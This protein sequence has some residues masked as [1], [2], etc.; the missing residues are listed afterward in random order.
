LSEG[1]PRAR[2][3]LA[4]YADPVG[5]WCTSL[6][7][8]AEVMVPCLE[9]ADA[10]SVIE[11]GAYSGD[12][13]RL[14]A[15]WA[16]KGG[17]KV[18]AV[19]PAPKAGLV[20][21]AEERE[22][23]ELVRETSLEGLRRVELADVVIIDGDHNYWTVSEEL[24]LMSERAAGGDLPLLMFHDVGWPHAF[25]DDYFDVG[26]IPEEHR[27]PV[28]GPDESRGLFPGDP[29]LRPGGLPYPRSAAREG[30]P[31]NGVRAAVEDFVEGRT[32]LRFVR[33]PAFFGFGVVWHED[34]PWAERMGELLEPWDENPVIER[35]EANRV[36]LLAEMQVRAAELWKE[37]ERRTRQEAL[38]RR[39]LDSSAFGL[40]ERLSRLR[41]RAGI[42]RGQRA[43]T[44]TEI[45]RALRE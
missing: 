27:H 13:T 29:G 25:R 21:L 36:R 15:D 44:K 40:A 24:R 5:G 11:I 9:L 33:V 31:R 28:A 8:V 14:L 2:L 22:E 16:A 39:L 12:L 41:I 34:A 23:V 10:R 19:D 45:R 43:I 35:L 17:A 3:D 6:S 32:G 7:N 42:A 37:R 38:L 20:Q 4:S 26:L 18:L 1:L 30:G